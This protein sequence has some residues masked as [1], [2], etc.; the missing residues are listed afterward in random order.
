MRSDDIDDFLG[1]TIL[2]REIGADRHMRSLY[3]MADRLTDVVQE[4]AAFG[5]HDVAFEFRR[6]EPREMRDLD[7]VRKNVLPVAR[8][9][10][11][12]SEQTHELRVNAVD[13]CLERRLFARFLDALVNFA[14]RLLDHLLNARGMNPPVLNE[15]FKRNARNLAAHGV[16]SREDDR[17]GRIVNDEIDARER[18]NRA[19]I[20]S[21]TPNDAPLHLIVRQGNDRDG[22]LR[23]M[24]RR[25]ALNG[26]AQNLACRLIRFVL[27]LTNVFLNLARL[28]MFQLFF[29]LR[30]EHCA[31]VL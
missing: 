13:A 28:L 8:T 6:H 29:R 10:A 26:N 11:H 16:K 25:A 23:D 4:S 18:F 20:S 30:H 15:F 27:R 24:I 7:G 19:N 31:R 2:A 14:P 1:L 12:P 21:L 22:R 3:L 17:L 9:V 5:K